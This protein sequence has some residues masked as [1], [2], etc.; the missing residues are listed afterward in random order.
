MGL[1]A[2]AVAIVILGL[3]G[4]RCDVSSALKAG[5]NALT[6]MDWP[7][8]VLAHQVGGLDMPLQVTCALDGSGRLFIVE[9]RGRIRIL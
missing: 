6:S 5:Q 9:Q 7:S 3:L 8:V 1:G 4:S 2:M